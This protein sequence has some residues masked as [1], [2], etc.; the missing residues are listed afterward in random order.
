MITIGIT[1]GIGS[2]KTTVS[3]IFRRKG[4]PVFNS[5]LAARATESDP[6]VQSEFKRIVGDDVI[7]NGEIDRATM[8]SRV[9]NDKAM[10][11][12]IND[13]ITPLVQDAFR[14]FIAEHES[15][16]EKIVALESAILFETNL[17]ADFDYIVS[18]IASTETRIKRVLARD[19][20]SLDLVKTKIGVQY[21]DDYRILKSDFIIVNEDND[22]YHTLLILN[23]QVS[24]ILNLINK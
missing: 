9:F 23:K 22:Y 8:R 17:T 2:G 13:L 18:V 6:F 19:K 16:G 14:V 3:N 7:V 4:I 12:Q 5:D 10:L 11:A 20:I 15:N 24:Q 21:P 1:G